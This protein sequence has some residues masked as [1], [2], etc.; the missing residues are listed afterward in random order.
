MKRNLSRTTPDSRFTGGGRGVNSKG[1]G[2][3]GGGNGMR[4][5]GGTGMGGKRGLSRTDV[6][7]GGTRLPGIKGASGG[8]SGARGAFNAP[9]KGRTKN[10]TG[11]R[12]PKVR[13]AGGGGGAK[14]AVRKAW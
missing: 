9:S 1:L 14:K 7:V 8:T 6:G 10:N 2:A 5:G 11:S 12:L 4:A 3:R 13:G